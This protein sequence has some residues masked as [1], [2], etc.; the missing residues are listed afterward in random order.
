[1]LAQALIDAG[2]TF[3]DTPAAVSAALQTQFPMVDDISNDEMF[4]TFEEV[5]RLQSNAE[6][7]LPLT[8]VV[9]DEMQQY[10]NDDNARP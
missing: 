4:D 2:A 6:G 7:K 5:L 8:L 1:M 10:I 3:G 9:L